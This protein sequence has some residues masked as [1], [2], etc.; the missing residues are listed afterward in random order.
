MA[1]VRQ[2]F[3]RQGEEGYEEPQ[4]SQAGVER[5]VE[6]A[7]DPAV[8]RRCCGSR[9][10]VRNGLYP[11]PWKRSLMFAPQANRSRA[12]FTLRVRDDD[13]VD[14]W[15]ASEAFQTFYGLEPAEVERLLGPAGP[16]A[17]QAAEI[18][19]LVGAARRAD[20]RCRGGHRGAQP[21]RRGTDETST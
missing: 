10:A 15:C 19:A 4:W 14:L 17:L 16:D 13:R 8:Q 1:L 11:R 12:L 5:V 7:S 2:S 3:D 6:E 20:G 18:A 9:G 21:R